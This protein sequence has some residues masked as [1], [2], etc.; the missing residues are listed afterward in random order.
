MGMESERL[1]ERARLLVRTA[2]G[3]RGAEHDQ[4]RIALL[5]WAGELLTRAGNTESQT[6]ASGA[7]EPRDTKAPASTSAMNHFPL[8]IF[9]YY[10]GRRYE[11]ELESNHEVRFQGRPYSSPSAAA[12]EITGN[13]VNGWR[14]WKFRPT[15]TS[16]DILIDAVR[17]GDQR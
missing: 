11:A 16:A 9:R 2:A 15:P 7:P 8:R 1:L 17:T 5:T 13:N 6:T 4:D 14:W 3:M 12:M 10:K